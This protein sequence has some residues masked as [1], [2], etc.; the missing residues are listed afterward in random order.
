M[1]TTGAAVEA[2]AIIVVPDTTDGPEGVS[3]GRGM[4]TSERVRQVIVADDDEL[5]QQLVSHKLAQRGYATRCVDNGEALLKAIDEAVPDLIVLDAMMPIMDGFEALR[6]LRAA[7]ASAGI[8][9]IMLTARRGEQDVVT[10]L[11]LG[12]SDYLA[13]PFMP[14]ELA[15]R[16]RA[17]LDKTA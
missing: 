10:A 14:E 7:P 8:P 13:K 15:L 11:N 9:V 1:P 6:R 2:D 17:L 4:T 3:A 5:L 12:A 16:V